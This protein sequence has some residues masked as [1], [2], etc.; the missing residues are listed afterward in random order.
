MLIKSKRLIETGNS[1]NRD[2]NLQYE[3]RNFSNNFF[4]KKKLMQTFQHVFIQ[5]SDNIIHLM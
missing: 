2:N 5:F 1:Q 3:V 4:F